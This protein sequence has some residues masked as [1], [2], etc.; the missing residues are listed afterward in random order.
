[1]TRYGLLLLCVAAT[2]AIA[3]PVDDERALVQQGRNAEAYALGTQHAELL[4]T[5]EFDFYFGIAAA[6]SGHVGEGVLALE[7]FSVRYP[8]NMVGRAELGRAYF[9]AGDD[10]RAREEFAT[11]LAATP[12]A[13]VRRTVERYLDLIATRQARYLAGTSFYAEAGYGWDSN[14]NGGVD[15]ARISLPIFGNVIVQSGAVKKSDTF[16]AVA[17]GGQYNRPLTSEWKLFGGLAVDDKSNRHDHANNLLET[18]LAAGAE[19]AQDADT[20][21]MTLSRDLVDVG[22]EH[23]RSGTALAGDWQHLLDERQAVLGSATVARYAYAGD[24][25]PR[26]ATLTAL[27]LAYRRALPYRWQPVLQLAVNA[28]REANRM[29]R[30]D[31]GRDIAGLRLAVDAA[32]AEAWTVSAG[33]SYQDSRYSDSDL[34]LA[35]RRRDAYRAV[36]ASLRYRIDRSLSVRGEVLLSDNRSNLELNRYRRNVVAVKLRFEM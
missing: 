12:D 17:A 2:G 21:R 13:A 27:G 1:M 28:G 19:H 32:P 14:T 29:D 33:M 36:D 4:G 35:T 6:D 22:S 5:P 3:G 15:D 34:L 25:A 26:D 23:F 7:R 18:T 24:N 10:E 20:Q 16:A 11:V 8:A 30:P 9:L 31:L